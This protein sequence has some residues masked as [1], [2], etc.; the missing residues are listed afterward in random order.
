MDILQ[1][2]QLWPLHPSSM[3]SFCVFLLVYD[4]R[5]DGVY[6]QTTLSLPCRL[7][8]FTNTK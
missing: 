1:T 4:I 3:N 6:C 5:L 2:P 8:V 7:S